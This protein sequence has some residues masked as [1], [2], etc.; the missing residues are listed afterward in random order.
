MKREMTASAWRQIWVLAGR[1]VGAGLVHPFFHGALSLGLLGGILLLNNQL[2]ALADNGL[3]VLDDPLLL[4]LIAVALVIGMYTAFNSA[5]RVAGERE[6]G[7]LTVLCFGP[8]DE[9][10]YLAA[11]WLEQVVIFSAGI[12]GGLLILRVAALMLGLPF[13]PLLA[14]VAGLSVLLGL[15]LGAVG[16]VAAALTSRIRTAIWAMLSLFGLFFGLQFGVLLL[17]SAT[18]AGPALIPIRD[19][20]EWAL[21]LIKI[22]SPFSY[23][24]KGVEGLQMAKAGPLLGAV[25]FSLAFAAALF[26]AA[27]AALRRKGVRR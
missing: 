19:G 22:V 10:I 20:L 6:S 25:F 12:G 1:N 21:R 26:G 16:L 17:R 15:C 24:L 27:V 2:S 23:F 11:Q 9:L 7:T 8:V 13:S 14:A 4:P 5:F 18:G 3:L